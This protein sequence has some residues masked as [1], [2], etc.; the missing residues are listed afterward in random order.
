M[1]IGRVVFSSE[2]GVVSS[3]WYVAITIC[4]LVIIGA[5]A[6]DGKETEGTRVL[7]SILD[8]VVITVYRTIIIIGKPKAKARALGNPPRSR[9]KAGRVLDTWVIEAHC[10]FEVIPSPEPEYRKAGVASFLDLILIH[11]LHSDSTRVTQHNSISSDHDGLE[12]HVE[13]EVSPS[14]PYNPLGINPSA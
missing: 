3:P 6:R 7:R 2:S 10:V 9:N 1:R 13:L 12:I 4:G 8:R 14:C 5:C 11:G